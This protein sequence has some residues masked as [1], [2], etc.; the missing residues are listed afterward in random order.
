MPASSAWGHRAG[1]EPWRCPRRQALGGR[2]DA[3]AVCQRESTP[4]PRRERCKTS[5]EGQPP[6]SGAE[7]RPLRIMAV[8]GSGWTSSNQV[9]HYPPRAVMR[10]RS[11]AG[12]REKS[13]S[14]TCKG[15]WRPPDSLPRGAGCRSVAEGG[16][17]RAIAAKPVEDFGG[18]GCLRSGAEPTGHGGADDFSI[19]RQNQITLDLGR[20]S[21]AFN[22]AVGFVDLVGVRQ[23]DP[24]GAGQPLR[25]GED[26]DDLLGAG[27]KSSGA[28]DCLLV[29]DGAA[30]WS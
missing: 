26:C 9:C 20:A 7:R 2:G 10:K 11:A 17:G 3:V 28:K 27:R 1:G 12:Y 25:P 21:P 23:H 6:P 22:P 16:G 15:W 19:A 14:L 30:G 8:V 4:P 24:H 18:G 5:V 13:R 29:G